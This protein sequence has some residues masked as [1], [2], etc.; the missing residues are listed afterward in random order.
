MS[1]IKAVAGS[2]LGPARSPCGPTRLAGLLALRRRKN[3][4]RSPLRAPGLGSTV[5]F[6]ASVAII[7]SSFV[8]PA[9]T[10][11][12]SAGPALTFSPLSLTNGWHPMG[13]ANQTGSP[14]AARSADGV[15]YLRGSL[16][17]GAQGLAFTLPAADRP[18]HA[19][20]V[21][22]TTYFGT[23]GTLYV[24]NGSGYLFG[25]AATYFSSL[26]GVSFPAGT[27]ATGSSTLTF[28]GLSPV[29]GWKSAQPQY[30]TGKPRVARS[31]AG[32]VYLDGSLEDGTPNQLAFV[33]PPADRPGRV[34][35]ISIYTYGFH[36]GAIYID[37]NG[38]A[39]VGGDDAS[40]FSS[41]AGI[42][43]PAANATSGSATLTLQTIPPANGWQSADDRGVL[44][45]VQVGKSPGVVYLEGALD[46]G[47]GGTNGGPAFVLPSPY[48]PVHYLHMPILTDGQTEGSVQIAPDGE[49][50]LFGAHAQEFASIAGIEFPVNS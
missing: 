39:F 37:P 38:N 43:F 21:P 46:V 29:G 48:R 33:L 27:A 45:A 18:A 5:V 40:L 7:A 35:A 42:S 10:T 20:Y 34:L 1:T 24:A 12:A 32:V 26:A 47:R 2:A 23:V 49:V 19:M 6:L 14:A 22:I 50:S 41:L 25:N 44:P 30:G 36:T 9:W 3:I 31:A 28:S 16:E 13:G 17:G 11:T 4:H 15:V 8:I